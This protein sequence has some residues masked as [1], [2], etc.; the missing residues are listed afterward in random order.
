MSISETEGY[1]EKLFRGT[2]VLRSRYEEAFS[3]AKTKTNSDFAA[4]FTGKSSLSFLFILCIFDESLCL[5]ISFDE[6]PLKTKNFEK[7]FSYHLKSSFRSQDI[8]FWSSTKMAW[9]E[10]R[11][12][13]K[14]MTSQPVKQTITMQ[15]LPNIPRSKGN[16]TMK[17]CQL[18][19]YN[20]RNIF[21]QKSCWN[22]AGRVVSGLFD[23]LKS[24]IWGNN[25]W[26]AA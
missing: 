10:I 9:L 23:F 16:Q 15:I 17:F 24:V 22:E 14:F 11:L 12:I 3:C 19:D 5:N 6:S 18:I 2:Y 20:K 1:F 13:S 25:K 26:S 4:K 7:C 8:T 21:L